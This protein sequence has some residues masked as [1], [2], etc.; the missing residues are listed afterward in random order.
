MTTTRNPALDVIS[1]GQSLGAAP[2]DKKLG[3]V[4]LRFGTIDIHG[5]EGTSRVAG[6]TTVKHVTFGFEHSVSELR[7]GDWCT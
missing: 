6:N 3:E 2:L 5:I 7:K 1:R 4:R